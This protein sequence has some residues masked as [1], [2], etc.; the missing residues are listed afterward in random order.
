[1]TEEITALEEVVVTGYSVQ[2]KVSLTGAISTVASEELKS[3]PTPTIAQ[4]LMGR[5]SG[6]F[7]KN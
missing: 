4:S 7:V 6:L 1:M 2:R 5:T 3:I